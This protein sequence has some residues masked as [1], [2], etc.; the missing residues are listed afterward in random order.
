MHLACLDSIVQ[1]NLDIPELRTIFDQGWLV[2]RGDNEAGS[3]RSLPVVNKHSGSLEGP[4]AKNR[5]SLNGVDVVASPSGLRIEVT[6]Y[7]TESVFL[8][9]EQ[10]DRLRLASR[11]PAILIQVDEHEI[12]EVLLD[13]F[14]ECRLTVVATVMEA[15]RLLNTC[16]YDA[17]IALNSTLEPDDSL[18]SASR[19]NR[20]PMFLITGDTESGLAEKC[21]ASGVVYIE[22]PFDGKVVRATVL[23]TIARG[24]E[25]VRERALHAR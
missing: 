10:I 4:M 19:P 13:I 15:D 25:V 8:T 18:F 9:Y 1:G 2:T 5:L 17:L 3:D 16:L 21:R 7:H 11:R 24:V 23:D 12:R 14:R 6:D 20:C 22:L